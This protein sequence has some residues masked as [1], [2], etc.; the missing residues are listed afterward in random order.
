MNFWS[1]QGI[2]PP[3]KDMPPHQVQ[4]VRRK[5]KQHQFHILLISITVLS[6]PTQLPDDLLIFKTCG[7]LPSRC[8]HATICHQIIAL[9]KFEKISSL[10]LHM[11]QQCFWNRIDALTFTSIMFANVLL[12]YMM[13]QNV[14][15]S[16]VAFGTVLHIEGTWHILIEW[17]K[18]QIVNSLK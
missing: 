13:V 6:S 2:L 10:Y 16:S 11:S 9:N 4:W 18:Y 8:H 7:F 5:K 3:M 14:I 15:L 1:Y 17:F 12:Y